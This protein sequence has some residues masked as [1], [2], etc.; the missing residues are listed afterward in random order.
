MEL[1]NHQYLAGGNGSKTV[2]GKAYCAKA[3][4][5]RVHERLLGLSFFTNAH[6]IV[7]LVLLN[8]C[9][10]V[11]NLGQS[12]KEN[13]MDSLMSYE[14]VKKFVDTKAL[15]FIALLFIGFCGFFTMAYWISFMNMG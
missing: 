10:L 11:S 12:K 2:A 7:C 4:I 15:V 1:V 13:I 6:L 5:E 14:K 9:Q 3:F 8:K